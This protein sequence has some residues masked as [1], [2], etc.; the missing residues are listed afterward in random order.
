MRLRDLLADFA[1]INV[2]KFLFDM[3]SKNKSIYS[4][5]LSNIKQK[6]INLENIENSIDILKKFELINL[7][8]LEEDKII[9]ISAKG[10][11]FM[12]TF[13]K[14]VQITDK[15][16]ELKN[17]KTKKSF[18]IK[19]HLTPKEKKIMIVLFKLS[20]ESGDR[21]ISLPDLTREIHPTNT[22][23]HMQ[24]ISSYASKLSKLNL[25]EKTKVK[26]QTLLKLTPTG[27][28]TIKEQLV[29][30]LL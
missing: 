16:N 20:K 30:S 21:P 8:S 13:D 1:A 2:L 5:K 28:R 18:Q 10:K 17:K 15:K 26:T 11:H 29:E 19:Y 27:E 12:D 7:D 6:F 23:N 9:S 22:E 3:E 24:N 4:T 25:I 14:L